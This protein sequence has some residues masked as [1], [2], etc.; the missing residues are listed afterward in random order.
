MLKSFAKTLAAVYSTIICYV[1]SFGFGSSTEWVLYYTELFLHCLWFQV[2]A[3]LRLQEVV[4]LFAKHLPHLPRRLRVQ[5]LWSTC[6]GMTVFLPLQRLRR[7][8]QISW[9]ENP[10]SRVQSNYVPIHA[11]WEGNKGISYFPSAFYS[12]IDRPVPGDYVLRQF[13]AKWIP[14]CVQVPWLCAPQGLTIIA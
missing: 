1:V 4:T 11:G 12:I 9:R 5:P 2:V 7:V 3:H 6:M 8:F 14:T 13:D 10:L